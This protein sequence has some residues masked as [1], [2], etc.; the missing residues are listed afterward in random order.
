MS[1][2][3]ANLSVIGSV[4]DQRRA[5]WHDRIWKAWRDGKGEA[6]IQKMDMAIQLLEDSDDK[7]IKSVGD[8]AHIGWC[9]V[10]MGLDEAMRVRA[11][12][13]GERNDA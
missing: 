12:S 4:M 3:E 13:E 7:L 1:E 9:S 8:L 5:A 11:E 2:L 6:F 10:L